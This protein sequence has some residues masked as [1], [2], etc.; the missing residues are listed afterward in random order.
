MIC[1]NC[2]TDNRDGAKYCDECGFPLAGKIAALTNAALGDASVDEALAKQAS[3]DGEG[4]AG[5]GQRATVPSIPEGTPAAPSSEDAPAFGQEDGRA[6]LAAD[7][8]PESAR[9]SSS[10]PL[11]PESIPAVGVVGVDADDEGHPVDPASFKQGPEAAASATPVPATPRSSLT[12]ADV[13]LGMGADATT[14]IDLSGFDESALLVGE[15]GERLVS[16]GYQVPKPSWRD[17]GTMEMPKVESE[18]PPPTSDFLSSST[19]KKSRKGL[20]AVVIVALLLLVAAGGAALA[21]HYE[22]WGGKSVP[23]VT[24]LPQAEAEAVL[25][26]QGFT[27]RVLE[28]KSDDTEGIVLVTDP[29]ANS[30]QTEGAQVTINVSVARIVPDI[31]GLSRESAEQALDAEGFTQVVYENVKSDEEEGTVVKVSLDAGTRAKSATE[32]V[33][34]IAEAYT[35]PDIAGLALDAAQE[36]I[37]DAGYTVNV[38]YTYTE[39]ITDGTILGTQPRAGDKLKSGSSV[40]IE[41]A[42][43]RGAELIAAAQSVVHSGATFEIGGT[44]YEVVSL[45]GLEYIGN[46]Q[47]AVTF[48]GR[49]YTSFLGETIYLSS[50][51]VNAVIS[52][53]DDNTVASIS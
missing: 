25:V 23:D 21:Y 46:N 4:A 38:V 7:P 20:F 35:V 17:G 30:R 22:L 24:G 18:A 16:S 29:G 10:G 51:T 42:R 2:R 39:R 12:P 47:T 49:P 31:V 28:V 27:V 14:V 36:A 45:D 13:D 41:V 6:G 11:T 52:W 48:T 15:M 9:P 32:I 8:A 44:R 50:R 26:E 19:K 33:V 5:E 34:S 53:N 37:K 43:S 1:P 3:P 40:T